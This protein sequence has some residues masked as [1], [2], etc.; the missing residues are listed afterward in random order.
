MSNNVVKL[1]QAFI[2][3]L[4]LPSGTEVQS[5]EY[6]KHPKWDSLAHMQL[7][8]GIESQFNIMLNTEDVI[9]LS[10]FKVAVDLL[11]KYGVKE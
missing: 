1:Q 8:A 3:A 11:K 4:G 6:G 9:A 5:L 2:T 7:I 10:S